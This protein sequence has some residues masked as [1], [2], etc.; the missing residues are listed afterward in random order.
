MRQAISGFIFVHMR[1]AISGF[2]FVHLY[3]H[4]ACYVLTRREPP[5]DVAQHFAFIPRHGAAVF[6]NFCR[7]RKVA[8][9]D[10]FI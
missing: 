6:K 4:W 2:I 10:R 5:L 7:W 3:C 8:T 1:Q 9:R